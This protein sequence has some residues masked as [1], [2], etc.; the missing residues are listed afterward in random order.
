MDYGL[1]KTLPV[2]GGLLIAATIWGQI[3]TILAIFAVTIT[4][5]FVIRHFWRR[6]KGVNTK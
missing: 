1:P 2:T 5:S 6:G 3:F 4:L